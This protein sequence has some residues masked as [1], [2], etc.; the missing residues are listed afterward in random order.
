MESELLHCVI[1]PVLPTRVRALE[2][3]ASRVG[4]MKFQDSVEAMQEVQEPLHSA[5]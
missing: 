4:G 5:E 1:A 3:F 2:A